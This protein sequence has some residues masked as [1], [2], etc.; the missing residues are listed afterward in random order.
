MRLFDDLMTRQSDLQIARESYMFRFF[1]GTLKAQLERNAS[2]VPKPQ[3]RLLMQMGFH[4]GVLGEVMGRAGAHYAEEIWPP[5]LEH[6]QSAIGSMME[7][8]RAREA[9]PEDIVARGF[10][11]DC[12]AW[13]LMTDLPERRV[14]QDIGLI[15]RYIQKIESIFSVDEIRALCVR[16]LQHTGD[17][18]REDVLHEGLSATSIPIP[19]TEDELKKLALT[20]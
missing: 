7:Y 6:F 13:W 20:A 4:H 1:G 9:I 8:R 2:W 17:D 18:A 14:T 19:Q 3:A 12:Y 16:L 15:F 10:A 11:S 5:S